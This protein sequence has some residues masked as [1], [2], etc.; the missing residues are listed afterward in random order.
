[1]PKKKEE[2]EVTEEVVV[3][4]VSE[5]SASDD[6]PEEP[7]NET[8]EP[9]PADSQPK[10]TRKKKTEP[11]DEESDSENTA[12][13]TE[14]ETPQETAEEQSPD[15]AYQSKTDSILTIEA[16]SNVTTEENLADIAWHEI[17][18]AYRTRRILTGFLGG[19]ERTE[20]RKNTCYCRVQR[21]SHFDSFQGNGNRDSQP[22]NG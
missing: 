6:L 7:I 12:S 5:V 18:N 16:R 11:M 14:T 10:R 3:D 17:H 2:L 20:K 4:S 13:I 8:N 19:L 22:T 9:V 15:R 1:M 21:L